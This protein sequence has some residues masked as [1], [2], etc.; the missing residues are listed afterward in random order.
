MKHK[1]DAEKFKLTETTVFNSFTYGQ[2]PMRSVIWKILSFITSDTSAHYEIAVGT[3]SMTYGS[4]T[5]FAVAITVYKEQKGAIFFYKTLR[6]KPMR[7]LKA[8]LDM[9]TKISLEVA[10]YL[11]DAFGEEIMN[12]RSRVHLS[13]HMDVGENGPTAKFIDDL[14]GWIKACGY[15]FCVKPDSYAASTIADRLSK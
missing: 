5:K 12:K 8:K 10:D 4:F 9:E 7:N 2:M 14:E 11:I 1:Q 3:D 6:S 13:I 15:D